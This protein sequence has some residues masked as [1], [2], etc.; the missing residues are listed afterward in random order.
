MA[1]DAIS[2]APDHYKV[3]LE[4]D[5]VRVLETVYGPGQASNMHSHPDTVVIVLTAAKGKFTLQDGQTVDFDMKAGESMFV[6]AQDHT[7]ENT[8][9]SELR[10]I[11]VELK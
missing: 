10:A 5:R 3:L 6:D 11:L 8:E 4:N 9:A 7:V 2:V 1:G